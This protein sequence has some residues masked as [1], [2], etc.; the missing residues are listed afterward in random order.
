MASGMPVSALHR[1]Q[2]R[3]VIT[4]NHLHAVRGVLLADGHP[5][6]QTD[7]SAVGDRTWLLVLLPELAELTLQVG[8]PPSAMA[9]W[10]HTGRRDPPALFVPDQG[11]TRHANDLGYLRRGQ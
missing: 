4:H 5:Q 9:G 2:R 6:V 7:R 8:Q 11:L 10:Q 3:T 1:D